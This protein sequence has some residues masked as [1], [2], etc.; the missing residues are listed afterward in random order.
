MTDYELAIKASKGAQGF[1]SSKSYQLA[2]Q[3]ASKAFDS[4][5]SC[6]A[7]FEGRKNVPAYV[8]QRNLMFGRKFNIDSIFSNTLTS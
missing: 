1:A 5:S 4:M 8:P 7:Q 6:E 3:A 2:S